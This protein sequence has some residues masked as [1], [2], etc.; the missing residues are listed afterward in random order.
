MR[1]MV[2]SFSWNTKYVGDADVI[3]KI[4]EMV[5]EKLQRVQ[6][7]YVEDGMYYHVDTDNDFQISV[8]DRD[9]EI[10]PA[11]WYAEQMEKR[12]EVANDE[13]A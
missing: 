6:L 4:A 13:C 12:K 10:K 5:D 9:Q 2:L 3:M 7:D 8:L 1:K 11:G